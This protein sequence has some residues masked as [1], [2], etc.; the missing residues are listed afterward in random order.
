MVKSIGYKAVSV[1]D[2]SVIQMT[3]Y[4]SQEEQ[5]LVI[6]KDIKKGIQLIHDF[7]EEG[8]P[9]I[10]GIEHSKGN[11]GNYDKTTDHWV[12]I[13]GRKTDDEGVHFLFF[14]PQTGNKNIGTSQKNKLTIQDNY[15]LEGTYR[16]GSKYE[17][18]YIVTMVRPIVKK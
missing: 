15:T 9:I 12:V 3:K 16:L 4:K 6:Q 18:K 8:K 11:T 5:I 2:K 1:D 14:D 17:K 7:L 10:V 13:V